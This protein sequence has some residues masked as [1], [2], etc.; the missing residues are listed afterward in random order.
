MRRKIFIFSSLLYLCGANSGSMAAC[1]GPGCYQ[2]TPAQPA[3]PLVL[4]MGRVKTAPAE[5][6]AQMP[7]Y[8]YQDP[9]PMRSVKLLSI[10]S[11]PD[12]DREP[13]WDGSV[14]TYDPRGYDKTVDW[15]DGVPIWDD[16]VPSYKYKDY[17][18]WFLQPMPELYIRQA[19]T[20]Y[21][22]VATVVAQNPKNHEE[23]NVVDL[24]K[25]NMAD[26]AATRARIEE[27]LRPNKPT[28][29][30]WVQDTTQTV[31]DTA[32]VQTAPVADT[33]VVSD[34]VDVQVAPAADVDVAADT[35]IT[36]NVVAAQT[37]SKEVVAEPAPTPVVA[38]GSQPQYT[39]SDSN[40]VT[41]TKQKN[42][43][44]IG[45]ATIDRIKLPS[46]R[47]E[48]VAQD[49]S[50]LVTVVFGRADGC[51]FDSETECQ[52]WRRKPIIRETV[53]PRSPLIRAE[54]MD[55]FIDA[56]RCDKNITA[57]NPLAA[58]LL[59]RYKMLM[60]SA[61]ACCTDGMVYSLKNAGASDGLI[62]KFMSDDANFY[63]F[64]ARCLMM[65]DSELDKKYPNTA[66]AAVAADVRNGCLCRGRQW[67]YAMLAPFQQAYAAFPEFRDYKFNYTYV[68]GL[69]R[70]ITVSVNNDVQNVLRQLALCP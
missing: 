47:P 53:A 11:V 31:T 29:N 19:D 2:I 24:Y 26:A 43:A 14:G 17:T 57:N 6:R 59:E 5:M 33:N 25:Q 35:V 70:E 40:L 27:L 52:I 45:D 48:Y 28:E 39:T 63:G 30:L 49:L 50:R 58:P 9:D 15:R 23:I 64:G 16:S 1:V 7:Q 46:P 44:I 38:D 61:N 41:V 36:A 21:E 37:V 55:E 60:G 69:Q 18:D 8:I 22:P 32:V 68:D 42:T 20:P 13:V 34:T 65:T 62:Y 66:T 3:D 10:K 51:P 12:D 4:E 56:A 67:F 54:K